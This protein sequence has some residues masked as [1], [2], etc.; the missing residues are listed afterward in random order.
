MWR[1]LG[2]VGEQTKT[3]FWLLNIKGRK[4]GT[5]FWLQNLKERDSLEHLSIDEI[6]QNNIKM[7]P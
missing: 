6:R 5:A 7:D 2:G 4:I 3:L 1:A